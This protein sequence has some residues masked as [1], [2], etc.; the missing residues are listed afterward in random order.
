MCLVEG[1]HEGS[2]A[3]TFAL[4]WTIVDDLLHPFAFAFTFSFT[5][6]VDVDLAL[7]LVLA[8]TLTWM[9]ADG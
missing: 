4:S 9:I 8:F 3:L 6:Q 2:V 1:R 7:V 5:F